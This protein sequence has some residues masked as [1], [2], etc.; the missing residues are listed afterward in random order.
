[1]STISNTCKGIF[2]E[3]SFISR[4]KQKTH[5]EKLNIV[6]NDIFNPNTHETMKHPDPTLKLRFFSHFPN[7]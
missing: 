2:N 6:M 7:E 1:M 5:T 3:F 4:N